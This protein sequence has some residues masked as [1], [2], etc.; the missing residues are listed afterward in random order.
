MTEENRRTLY[1]HPFS[2]AYW[3]Q[4][5][6]EMKSVR[7]LVFAALMIALRVAMKQV[8]I[9][10]AAD[11][12]I[13]TAFIVNALGAMVMGPVLS[14]FAAALTDTLGCALFPTGP[15]FFPFIFVE[16]AGSV[17]FALFLYRAEITP[18]RIIGARFC[19]NFFVNIVL[20]TPIMMLYYQMMMG[21][22][23]APFDLLR[24]V[25]NLA[26]FPLEA[27]V[28]IVI[29]R[30]MAPVFRRMGY[31]V[32]VRDGLKLTKRAAALLIVLA[33]TGALAVGGY[34][35]L[36]YN[37]TS[38]SASYTAQERY[39]RNVALGGR[40]LEAHPELNPEETVCVI[41]SA[42]PKAFSDEVTYTVAVYRAEIPEGEDADTLLKSLRGLSKSKAAASEYLTRVTT[43]TLVLN[44]K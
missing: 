22:Y 1:P 15:Y 19:I 14:A 44:E 23:Y 41:E 21:K 26:L 39:E 43:E 20:N 6:A 42:Y 40:V 33:L 36:H 37:N 11:L 24:I 2:K 30:G 10:I 9:P 16:I 17:I 8:S 7:M 18:G 5:L 35:W 25:K 27:L 13:N 12:R 3:K 29:I 34:A 32:S 28:L 4:A 38:L 31:A